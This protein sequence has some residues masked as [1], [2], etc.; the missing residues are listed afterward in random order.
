[1]DMARSRGAAIRS[2]M[3]GRGRRRRR[4][5]AT[6]WTRPRCAAL[7]ECPCESKRSSVQSPGGDLKARFPL[8]VRVALGLAGCVGYAWRPVPASLRLAPGVGK[9]LVDW[10]GIGTNYGHRA[11][12]GSI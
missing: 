6:R 9:S 1:M 7:L 2:D 11:A 3:A 5:L 10:A 8:G 12:A 4:R